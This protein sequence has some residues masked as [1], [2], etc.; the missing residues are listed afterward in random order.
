MRRFLLRV[1]LEVAVD[2][3]EA[4][5][6]LLN[7]LGK[8]PLGLHVDARGRGLVHLLF[9]PEVG[10]LEPVRQL[11]GRRLAELFLDERVVRVPSAHAL[12]PGDDVVVLQR[13]ALE[14]HRQLRHLVPAEEG[15]GTGRKEKGNVVS[16]V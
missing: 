7:D 13:L 2:A 11:Y 3:V 5:R 16:C 10:T 1:L 8:P 4:L 6:T 14:G 9:N 15:N 12:R